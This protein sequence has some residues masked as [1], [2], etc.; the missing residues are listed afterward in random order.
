MTDSNSNVSK[1][2]AARRRI[3]KT[4]LAGGGVIAGAKALPEKWAKPVVESVVLPAHAQGSPVTAPQVFTTST[5]PGPGPAKSVASDLLDMIIPPAEAN[6]CTTIPLRFDL[7][8]EVPVG[9]DGR[10]VTICL[11]V[12]GLVQALIP[13][14]TITGN[15]ITDFGYVGAGPTDCAGD[16]NF[17][18]VVYTTLD[19]KGDVQHTGGNT[20]CHSS[21]TAPLVAAPFSCPPI[22][23]CMPMYAPIELIL[24]R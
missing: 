11:N 14:A 19:V 15:A 10:P 20:T 17:T 1:S 13:G 23:N 2:N 7:T 4:L 16:W 8:F 12:S 21:F 3:L 9:S 24:D 5:P 18:N 22:A 6:G